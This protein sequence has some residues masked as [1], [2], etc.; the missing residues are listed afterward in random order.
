MPLHPNAAV[1]SKQQGSFSESDGATLELENILRRLRPHSCW[2]S[3]ARDPIVALLQ[4][5]DH[6]PFP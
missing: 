6:I 5:R 3:R 4:R 1:S 2:C